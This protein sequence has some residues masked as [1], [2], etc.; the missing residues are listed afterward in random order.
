MHSVTTTESFEEDED[1]EADVDSEPKQ[2][3]EHMM[4]CRQIRCESKNETYPAVTIS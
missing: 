2:T 4:W 1:D 3:K